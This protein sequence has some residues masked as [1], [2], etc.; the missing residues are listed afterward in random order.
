VFLSFFIGHICAH[1]GL[2]QGNK[3]VDLAT[4]STGIALQITP[5]PVDSLFQAKKAHDLHHLNSCTLR[6]K[7]GIF[8]EQAPHIV[9]NCRSCLTFLPEAHLQVNP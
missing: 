1:Y 7:F 6:Y 5:S 9:H 4:Q 3:C 2:A 8:T